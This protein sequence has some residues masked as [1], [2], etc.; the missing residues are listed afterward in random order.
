MELLVEPQVK[1]RPHVAG[2]MLKAY[3]DF[4]R[5]CQLAEAEIQLDPAARLGKGHN[6]QSLANWLK[7]LRQRARR[8]AVAAASKEAEA[9]VVGAETSL[10]V[11]SLVDRGT[12][13][14]WRTLPG[15]GPPAPQLQPESAWQTGEAIVA[16]E[17]FL[18]LLLGIWFL[19]YFPRLVGVL[20]RLWPEQLLLIA[21][22]GW[23]AFG[24]S[25]VGVG[26]V[27]LA[28]LARI[29]I[30]AYWLGVRLRQQNTPALA[31]PAGVPSGT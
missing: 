9:R 21:L 3:Q 30:L 25:L 19:S 24:P 2:P 28:I 10:Q 22:A 23:A 16:T 15:D 12:P 11:A 8:L 27:L 29:V 5:S 31:A 7:E 18:G 17:V 6:G 14:R 20:R 1:D 13:V 26:L 4:I